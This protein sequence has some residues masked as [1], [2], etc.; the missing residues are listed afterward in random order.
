MIIPSAV[1]L[2][3]INVTNYLGGVTTDNGRIV[4][5]EATYIQ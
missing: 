5:A 2:T 4:A 3:P 1:F